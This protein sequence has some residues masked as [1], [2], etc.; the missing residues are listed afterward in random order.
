MNLLERGR[1]RGPYG[2]LLGLV[3]GLL[4]VGTACTGT[5][6][7]TPTPTKPAASP[8]ATGP[9]PYTNAHLVVET[10]W[11]AQHLNDAG[12]RIVDARTAEAYAAGHIPGAVSIP[13]TDTFNPVG[14][15]QMAGT[16]EQITKLLG[17]KGI[18]N[19]TKVVVYADGKDNQAARIFWTLEYYGLRDK[20]AVL[21]GGFKKWQ[22]ENRTISTQ[23]PS[24]TPATF[25]AKIDD[26]VLS[27]KEKI[28][29]IIGKPGVALV[30]AR[31]PAEYK[32]E[33]LRAK[34]GGHIPGAVNINWETLFTSDAAPVL[35]SAQE[36]AAMYQ[37]VGVT[38]DKIAYV[39]CQ[40]GQRS[41]VTYL[42]LRLLGYD[43]VLNYD[44][45]WQEWGNDPDVPI[46]K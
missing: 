3:L 26:S 10:A 7:A 2:L 28:L 13:V 30:D 27:T 22:A 17:A 21:N 39:Y 43:K 8:T 41:S 34:R 1:A 5:G 31:S 40:T 38:K 15:A 9:A 23:V 4:A 33:D 44:G 16:V 46:E 42:S 29:G 45:S 35:K 12:Q 32:G 11:L 24:I 20:V 14:P 36:L 25:T 37:A 6:T 19:D 18:G